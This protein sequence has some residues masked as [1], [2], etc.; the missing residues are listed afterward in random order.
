MKLRIAILS[1]WHVHAPGYAKKLSER[2]DCSIIAVWDE[3]AARGSRFAEQLN[4]PYYSDLDEVLASEEV[5]AVIVNASTTK[6]PEVIIAA[7]E[8]GKHIFTEKVLALRTE[9]ADRIIAAAERR[10]IKLTVSLP[11]L[12]DEK[13]LYAKQVL[14]QELLGRITYVR[15]RLAHDG[16]LPREGAPEGWLP[17]HFVDRESSGGGALID[18]GAHPMVLVYHFLGM[19]E[20]VSA[21]FGYVTGREVEDNAVVTMQ[22]RDGC[23][24]V[25]EAGFASRHS[26]ALVE[27]YGTE[28][29]LLIGKEAEI[30]S[31]L[32]PAGPCPGWIKPE[33]LPA[34]MPAPLDQWV[35]YVLYDK[36]T[37][38]PI[39]HG[40][41]LTQLMEAAYLS[42][43]E[44]RIVAIPSNG[45]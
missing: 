21:Q 24:A 20:S 40:L 2:T 31:S 4:V 13:T 41:A 17:P 29:C 10:G 36:P 5:D 44:R 30:R 34:G 14:E 33:R 42:A 32:L 1:F 8:A 35:E 9:E 37:A 3:D 15:M 18:L 43:A 38:I 26:P 7:A 25:V 16:L 45:D 28:G 12:G 39:G 23:M 11:K 27:I 19:P 6:H 22:Y